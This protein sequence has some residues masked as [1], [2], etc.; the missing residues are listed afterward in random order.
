MGLLERIKLPLFKSKQ[1]LS[2]Q[3]VAEDEEPN[4]KERS[5]EN[6]DEDVDVDVETDLSPIQEELSSIRRT[7]RRYT[8]TMLHSN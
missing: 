5:L 7:R 6:E 3:S 2:A 1:E 8:A 4:D